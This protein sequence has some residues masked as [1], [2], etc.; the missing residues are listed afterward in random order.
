MNIKSL[1][2]LI[3]AFNSK[4]NPT[5]NKNYTFDNFVVG[6][7]NIYAHNVAYNV[8]DSPGGIY[9]PYLY[10]VELD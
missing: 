4:K 8:A 10:T 7:G 6:A 9:N 3:N 2:P 1:L 5:L